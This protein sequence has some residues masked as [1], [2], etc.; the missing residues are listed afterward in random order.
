MYIVALVYDLLF[1]SFTVT[2]PDCL[3]DGGQFQDV[4]YLKSS[5]CHRG[6]QADA[7]S[8]PV[9]HTSPLLGIAVLFRTVL[10]IGISNGLPTKLVYLPTFNDNYSV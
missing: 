6:A 3:I 4:F 5:C 8:F 1:S 9:M 7:S 10:C 2:H